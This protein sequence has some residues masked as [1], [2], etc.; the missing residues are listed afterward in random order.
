[1]ELQGAWNVSPE[2]ARTKNAVDDESMPDIPLPLTCSKS[3]YEF[4]LTRRTRTSFH[5]GTFHIV[6]FVLY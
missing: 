6:E 2:D 4:G 5:M 3:K 1:M